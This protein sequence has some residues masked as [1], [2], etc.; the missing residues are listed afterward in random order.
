[1][2]GRSYASDLTD[3]Q[4][5]LLEPVFNAPCKRGP[6]HAPDLRQVVDAMLVKSFEKTTTSATGWLRVACIAATLRHLSRSHRQHRPVP[7]AA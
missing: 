3:E 5:A 1:M 7:L 4:W 2:C 6:K